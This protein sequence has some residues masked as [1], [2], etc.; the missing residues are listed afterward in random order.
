MKQKTILFITL[1]PALIFA[2][3]NSFVELNTTSKSTLNKHFKYQDTDT[4]ENLKIQVAIPNTGFTFGASLQ[5]RSQLSV[6][7]YVLENTG[8]LE[9]LEKNLDFLDSNI[10]AKYNKNGVSVLTK[11]NHRL[12]FTTELDYQNYSNPTEFGLHSKTVIPL[13]KLQGY[14]PIYTTVKGFVQKDLGKFKD[15]RLDLETQHQINK[16]T[17]SLGFQYIKATVS[18]RYTDIKDWKLY[19]E[20]KIK[21]QFDST[22]PIW[23]DSESIHVDCG[24]DHSHDHTNHTKEQEHDIF[25]HFHGFRTESTETFEN[26]KDKKYIQNHKFAQSYMLGV[27]YTGLKDFK[28]SGKLKFYHGDNSDEYEKIVNLTLLSNLNLKYTGIKNLTISN[29]IT[30]FVEINIQ[31]AG[32]IVYLKELKNEFNIKYRYDITDKLD[33]TPE[34]KVTLQLRGTGNHLLYFT[35]GVSINYTPTNN[36]KITGG[37]NHKISMDF[38]KFKPDIDNH[39]INANLGI[40]YTW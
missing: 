40:K 37:V 7:P 32:N 34:G 2:K 14:N 35:P 19:G 13:K 4:N 26:A 29:S 28:I 8:I 3:E 10:Y 23:S 15:V 38:S 11:L 22:S 30:S 33:I 12:K 9:A 17:T 18:T 24:H 16:Y 20:A 1:L 27:K 31:S 6:F 5:H 21:Y 25:S 39:N 36:F